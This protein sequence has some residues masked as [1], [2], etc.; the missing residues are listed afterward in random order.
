MNII[1]KHYLNHKNKTGSACKGFV[2]SLDLA[3]AFIAML[4]MLSLMLSQLE[5]LKNEEIENEIEAD[6]IY[7]LLKTSQSYKPGIAE[8]HLVFMKT[9]LREIVGRLRY[10]LAQKT[11]AY[12]H[13]SNT[14]A[15]PR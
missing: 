15:N 12:Y 7:N 13:K 2:F 10:V 14:E 11:A 5:I 3:I 9:V 1:D 6:R 8:R 4:L